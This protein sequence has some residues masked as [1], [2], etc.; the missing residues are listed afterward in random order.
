MVVGAE[1][2]CLPALRGQELP[3]APWV[4]APVRPPTPGDEASAV[5]LLPAGSGQRG[6]AARGAGCRRAGLEERRGQ[7]TAGAPLVRG[8][9]PQ[10]RG[11]SGQWSWLN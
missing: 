10:L 1:T 5:A 8:D 11:S 9:L 2:G 4:D 7:A 6:G 3:L